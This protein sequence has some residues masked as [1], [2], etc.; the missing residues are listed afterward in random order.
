MNGFLL[1]PSLKV[2]VRRPKL[3]LLATFYSGVWCTYANVPSFF[4]APRDLMTAIVELAVWSQ[5]MQKKLEGV[6]GLY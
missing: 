2:T 1:L 5:K 4:V 3:A 6:A